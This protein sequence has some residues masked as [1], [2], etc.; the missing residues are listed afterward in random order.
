[1]LTDKQDLQS[2]R[3][4][5]QTIKRRRT[6]KIVGQIENENGGELDSDTLTQCNQLLRECISTSGWAPF[7]YARNVDGLVEPWRFHCLQNQACLELA[8][9]LPNWV[10]LKPTSKIPQLLRG[11]HSLVLVNWIPQLKD[12]LKKEEKTEFDSKKLRRINEEHL[13]ATAA[14]VQNLLLLCETLNWESYWSSGGP[15]GDQQ[16]FERLNINVK[17]RLVAAVFVHFSRVATKHENVISGKHRDKRST[18]DAWCSEI[19]SIT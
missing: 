2:F 9:Q 10:S 6:T 14:A 3:L 1:M 5:Q 19:K 18:T 7:H 15:L 8:E 13:A 4:L 11:C 16:V 12:D 17:E